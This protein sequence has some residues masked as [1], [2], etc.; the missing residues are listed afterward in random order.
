MK[1]LFSKIALMT[2]VLVI[3]F[4][5]CGKHKGFTKDE[6]GFYYKFY[7]E[8]TDS[9][10]LDKGSYV[11]FTHRLYTTDTVLFENYPME[12]MIQDPVFAGDLNDALMHLHNGDSVT[13]IFNADSFAHYYFG[14]DDFQPDLKEREIWPP[15]RRHSMP[16]SSSIG[17]MAEET[18]P[19][20]STKVCNAAGSPSDA[21]IPISLTVSA[22]LPAILS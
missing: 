10:K 8:N 4:A 16:Y 22:L 13:L 5:S 12:W 9:A 21:I 18:T 20:T 15:N 14:M 1:N 2:M 3:T 11:M 17:A 6:T 7:V 19:A